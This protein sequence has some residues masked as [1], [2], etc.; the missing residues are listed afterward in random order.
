VCNYCGCRAIEPVAR[1]TADH[2]RIQNLS[3]DVRRAVSRDDHA[4]AAAL[5][6]E[7]HDVL[8]VHDAVEELAVYPAMARHSE[9]AD[10]IGTMF[11]EHDDLDDV[12]RTALSTA[13]A[14]DPAAADWTEV[15]AALGALVE[16]IQRE[17]YGLF[18]AAAIALD[19]EEWEHA[20]QVRSAVLA[21]QR[22]G[23]ATDASAREV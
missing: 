6:R 22:A 5:L 21:E 19:P 12:L 2:E 17:E 4:T 3:G 14:A 23:S 11:D 1:L 9:Y 7:L 20:A 16:H 15:L 10:A 8:T 13:Q 18:P